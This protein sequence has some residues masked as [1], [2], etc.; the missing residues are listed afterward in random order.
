MLQTN[1]LQQHATKKRVTVFRLA[2]VGKLIEKEMSKNRRTNLVLLVCASVISMFGM[3]GAI[4]ETI[5]VPK[6]V[7]SIQGAIDLAQG[8]DIV[9]VAPG[10]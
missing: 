3:R 4:A 1:V 10:R 6:E 5:H 9:V 8:D 2:M 7:E